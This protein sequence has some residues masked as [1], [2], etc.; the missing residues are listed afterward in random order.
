MQT[1][2][3]TGGAGFIGSYTVKRLIGEGHK[4]I[5]VDNFN[6][7]YDPDLKRARINK[8]LFGLR[9][10][11]Y[12][13]DIADFESLKE[14][15]KENRI[16]VVIH[17]AAQAGVRYSLE[18]PFVYEKS[19]IKGTLSILECCKEF[20]IKK[21]IFAS[22]SS[23]YGEKSK[24]PFT[25]EDLTDNPV[26]LYA[27]TK[28]S[29]EVICHS[30]HSLYK[31]PMIGLRYFTVY[32]PWGRPDMALFKF[33]ERILKNKPID[34]YGRGEMKRDF[35]Y[36]DDIIEGTIRAFKKD[37][38]FEIFNLGYGSPS[39]LMEF[40]E[41][42]ESCLGKKTKKNFLPMQKGDVPVTYAGISKAKEK[43]GWQPVV[44][45]KEGVEKFV[46]WYEEYYK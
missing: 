40:I 17:Q 22:S 38:D 7:Y 11:L 36:I 33:T 16:D 31:I 23:V 42:I 20:K 46:R 8:L 1:V 3:V 44:S 37:F 2:L 41:I 34:V 27:A 35:T 18:N 29:T 28:K 39:G 45:L 9:F 14:I 4:V 25:E 10:K 6:K 43:L 32:G 21:I 19:N 26:S 15:F 13:K 5:I 12:E 30:Y 24:I